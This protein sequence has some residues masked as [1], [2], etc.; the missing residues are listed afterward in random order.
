VPINSRDVPFVLEKV[1]ADFQMVRVQGPVSYRIAE[2][3]KAAAALNFALSPTGKGDFLEFTSGV[4][5]T[6]TVAEKKGH[7][8]H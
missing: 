2:P 8:V 1:T 7:L 3:V 5:A 6:I 4:T